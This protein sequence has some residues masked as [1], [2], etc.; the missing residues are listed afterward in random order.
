MVPVNALISLS[1]KFKLL[2]CCGVNVVLGA[3][4]VG[5]TNAGNENDVLDGVLFTGLEKSKLY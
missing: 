4:L 1:I 2:C 3:V 5:V